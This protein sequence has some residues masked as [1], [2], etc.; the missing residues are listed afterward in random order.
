VSVARCPTAGEIA[1]EQT[2]RVTRLP[3]PPLL[4]GKFLGFFT[5]SQAKRIQ[6]AHRTGLLSTFYLKGRFI[7]VGSMLD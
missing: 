6:V 7:Y 4:S 5:Y 2:G 3:A 1:S